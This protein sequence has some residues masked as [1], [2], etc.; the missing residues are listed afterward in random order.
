MLKIKSIIVIGFA[1]TISLF[2]SVHAQANFFESNGKARLF[3]VEGLRISANIKELELGDVLEEFSKVTGIKVKISET[4]KKEKVTIH[5]KDFP[6]DQCV[7]AIIGKNYSLIYGSATSKDVFKE[8]G[9][10][11]LLNEV[12]IF[13]S[14]KGR[15]LKYKTKQY[16]FA[17]NPY[18]LALRV[19]K[20]SNASGRIEMMERIQREGI[21]LDLGDLKKILKD[22]NNLRVKQLALEEIINKL[23][24]EEGE[25][26]LLQIIEKNS[27]PELKEFA[28]NVMITLREENDW[29]YK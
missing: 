3:N 20:Y 13:N 29:M 24:P 15:L 14:L 16:V 21:E 4:R 28:K 10:Y 11:S 19:L 18:L 2:F 23:K 7:K 8:F 1:V 27:M 25:D 5:C 9:Y 12:E 26:F 22:D 17:F 6:L